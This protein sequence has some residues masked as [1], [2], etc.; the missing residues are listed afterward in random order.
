MD[1][2]AFIRYS[3]PTK[4]VVGERNV[5]DGEAKLL[6]STKGRTV[7]LTPLAPAASWD[8]GDSI[9]KLFDE[10]NGDEQE[11][12]TEKGDDVLEETIATDIPE[13]VVE[14]TKKN[15]RSLATLRGLIPEDS[16]ASKLNLQARPLVASYV[17]LSDDSHHLGLCFEVNSFDRSSVANAPVVTIVATTTIAADVSAVPPP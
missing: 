5:A 6:M 4:V 7:P 8:S 11:R 12:S 9:D 14:E 1:L 10:G 3:D 13:I 15:E 17:V 2:F 16:S